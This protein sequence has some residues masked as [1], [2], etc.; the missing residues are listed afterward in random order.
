[1]PFDATVFQ[2]YDFLPSSVT[3]RQEI[4]EAIPS[5]IEVLLTPTL[6][7]TTDVPQGVFDKVTPI[8]QVSE[9]VLEQSA[10]IML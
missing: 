2:D 4:Q 1:M 8:R 6:Y 9:D 10:L 3:D 7:S 5:C